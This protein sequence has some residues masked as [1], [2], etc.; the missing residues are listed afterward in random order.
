MTTHLCL[1]V[2]NRFMKAIFA[3]SLAL[4]AC[5]FVFCGCHT[6][7][8]ATPVW[9]YRVI[10]AQPKS[11]METAMNAAAQDGWEVVTIEIDSSNAAYVVLRRVKK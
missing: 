3:P 7:S 2:F 6:V 4:A 9:E 1:S 8:P 5:A 10:Q 11:P